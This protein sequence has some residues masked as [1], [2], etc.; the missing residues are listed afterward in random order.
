[1][2]FQVQLPKGTFCHTPCTRDLFTLWFKNTLQI[3]FVVN[4]HFMCFQ[5]QLPNETF[6]HISSNKNLFALWFKN[7]FQ[8]DFVVNFHFMCFQVQL[9]NETFCHTS[10]NKNLFALWFRNTSNWLWWIFISCSFKS[11]C[12]MEPFATDCATETCLLFDSKIRSKLTFW[13]KFISFA[14]KLQ[15]HEPVWCNTNIN[16]WAS[17]MQFQYQ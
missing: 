6:C 3:Y 4:V 7:T 15:Y 5:V 9:S 11:S 13:W 10:S 17:Q 12:Q 1:M 14:F 8:T 2:C 16:I